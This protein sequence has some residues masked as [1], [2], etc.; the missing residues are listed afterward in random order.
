MNFIEEEDVA[1]FQHHQETLHLT[2]IADV[3]CE[4]RYAVRT[5][6]AAH[7]FGQKRLPRTARSTH[8]QMRQGVFNASLAAIIEVCVQCRPQDGYGSGLADDVIQARNDGFR[9]LRS[10]FSTA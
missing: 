5:A 3:L 6:L 10:W 2:G 4:F 7:D 9:F 1:C 8:Q